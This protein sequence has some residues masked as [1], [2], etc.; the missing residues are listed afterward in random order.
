MVDELPEIGEARRHVRIVEAEIGRVLVDHGLGEGGQRLVL[1]RERRQLRKHPPELSGILV[2]AETVEE[3]A[4]RMP[5]GL[6]VAGR[7]VDGRNV[8]EHRGNRFR[9]DGG[10]LRPAG[11]VQR[12]SSAASIDC[13]G[14]RSVPEARNAGPSPEVR[15]R[16]RGGAVRC[17]IALSSAAT[18][19]WTEAPPEANVFG[20]TLKKASVARCEPFHKKFR[21][22]MSARCH[23]DAAVRRE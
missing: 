13:G 12:S 10:L 17:A 3:G 1:D 7:D 22:S 19:G 8:L 2:T 4:G 14:R 5:P 9:H 15:L 21:W 18:N 6:A 11:G 16:G 23:P 20:R